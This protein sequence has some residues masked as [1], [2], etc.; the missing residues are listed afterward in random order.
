M[1]VDV[2]VGNQRG[3][4]GKGSIVDYMMSE[5]QIGARYGGG[6]NAGHT[7]VTENGQIQRLHGLPTSILREGTISI[8]GNGCVIYP[9]QLF[10]EIGA[11]TSQ[12]IDVNPGNLYISPAAHLTL[13][14]YINEEIILESGS[15]AQGSTK[16]GIQGAYAAKTLRKGVRAEMINNDPDQLLWITFNRLREQRRWLG[17][18]AGFS[19]KE[20]KETARSYVE[21]A[22][23]IGAFVTEDTV[24]LLNNKLRDDVPA[25]VLA[26]GAQGFLLD[27]DHGMYPYTTSSSTT[28]GGVCSGLGIAPE[29]IRKVTGM[30]KAVQSHVGGG[31]F[32]TEIHNEKNLAALYGDMTSVDAE[33]GVTTGRTRR[34]GFLDLPQIRR[35]QLVNGTKDHPGYGSN[36]TRLGTSFW[37]IC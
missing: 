32:V 26:E 11:L 1:P 34:L 6:N 10:G 29:F 5:Y 7:S 37:K 9:P 36:K 27:L 23:A 15:G 20:D 21:A 17:R 4:E 14:S 2:V 35:A 31:P 3:D 16:C 12:G 33:R 25:R 24:E 22:K 18:M 8:I 30:S 19:V 13:P 28:V